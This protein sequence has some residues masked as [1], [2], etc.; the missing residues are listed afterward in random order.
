MSAPAVPNKSQSQ[1]REDLLAIAIRDLLGPAGG[2]EEEI[3]EPRVRERYLTG[4]LAPRKQ[5]IGDEETDEPPKEGDLSIDPSEQDE[6]AAAGPGSAEEGTPERG[7][8]SSPTLFPCSFGLSFCVS[9][10]ASAIQVD[11]HW[12]QYMRVESEFA[13]KKDGS[14]KLV[15]KRH[16]R[17]RTLPPITLTAGKIIDQSIDSDC[18]EVIL[19]GQVRHYAD[20]GFVANIA[21]GKLVG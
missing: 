5:E 20:H 13:K 18:S 16:P 8:T 21:P 4:M 12:G 3:D 6:L 15:W 2:Q 10:Q 9:L 7:A 11:A 19:R 17:G 14:P 1:I